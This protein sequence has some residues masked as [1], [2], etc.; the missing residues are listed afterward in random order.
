MKLKS[1]FEKLA[2]AILVIATTHSESPNLF[3]Q[4]T[5]HRVHRLT[6][7]ATPTS[8]A[9]KAATAL[10]RVIIRH[11]FD[12]FLAVFWRFLCNIV[13]KIL[14][15]RHFEIETKTSLLKKCS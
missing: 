9:H 11:V 7:V 10:Q 8:S 14:T 1:H 2:L 13:N 12:T 6:A 3:P 4:D 15:L 5:D